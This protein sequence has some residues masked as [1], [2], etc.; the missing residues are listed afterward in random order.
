[1]LSSESDS[2]QGEG[3]STGEEDNTEAGKSG[4]ETSSDKQE[5]SNGEDQQGHPHTQ[6]TLTS[7]SLLF[8]KHEDTDPKSD[9]GEKVSTA[10]AVQGQPQ[11][12]QPQERLQWIIIFRGRATN[13]RGV[14]RQ[15]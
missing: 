1:M 12:G 5:A 14:Q 11:G 2:S 3:Y 4:I 13:Q 9:S 6:D 15:S 10:K 8:I 7:V